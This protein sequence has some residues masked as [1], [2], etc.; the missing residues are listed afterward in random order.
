MLIQL[1]LHEKYTHCEMQN[2]KTKNSAARR[3]IPAGRMKISVNKTALKGV[4]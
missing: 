4:V 3:K 2:T 1:S